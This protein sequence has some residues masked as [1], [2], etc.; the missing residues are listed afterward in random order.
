MQW[1]RGFAA[2][3]SI[4][5]SLIL[6]MLLRHGLESVAVAQHLVWFPLPEEGC[7]K[8]Q[9]DCSQLV[10]S[11][12]WFYALLP[13]AIV[14][15]LSAGILLIWA[16]R[17][18]RSFLAVYGLSAMAALF[19]ST[20][21][22]RLPFHTHSTVWLVWAPL[23]AAL[24]LL[25]A[26]LLWLTD[27]AGSSVAPKGHAGLRRV[28]WAL[29][30]NRLTIAL[31][32]IYVAMF[33]FV[34][35]TSGQAIDA[36]RQWSFS[37]AGGALAF[38][39]LASAFLLSVTIL[40]TSCRLEVRRRV[41]RGAFSLRV[42]VGVGI[43]CLLGGAITWWAGGFGLGVVILGGICLVMALFDVLPTPQLDNPEEL[44][45]PT[46]ASTNAPTRTATQSADLTLSPIAQWLVATPLAVLGMALGLVALDGFAM[47]V[48]NARSWLVL[49][50]L[51]VGLAAAFSMSAEA[52]DS[53]E[54]SAFISHRS[55][56][57][58]APAILASAAA[59][60]VT[61]SPI[62]LAVVVT[63][64]AA[65]VLVNRRWA[66]LA[67]GV[68]LSIGAGLAA[69]V[70]VHRNPIDA[71]ESI[72]TI[73]LI[74]VALAVQVSLGFAV[75]FATLRNRPPRALEWLGM[76]VQPLLT[77]LLVWWVV[78]GSVLPTGMHQVEVLQPEPVVGAPGWSRATPGLEQAFNAWVAAQPEFQAESIGIP[79]SGVR[80]DKPV[81]LMLV[82]AHGGGIRAAYWTS[83][84]MDCV[85][86]R[87]GE[88]GAW[89]DS[90]FCS[91][92]A[93]APDEIQAAA[94]RV[95]LASGVSGGSVGL[96]AYSQSL[97]SGQLLDDRTWMRQLLGNDF[98]SP[99]VGWGL[100][101][102]LPNHFLGLAPGEE[103]CV[104]RARL[105]CWKRDRAA[106]LASQLDAASDNQA[107]NL[108]Q[109]WDER[110][111]EDEAVRTRAETVPL[112]VF[113]STLVGGSG[114]AIVSAAKLGHHNLNLDKSTNARSTGSREPM[115]LTGY[116]ETIDVLCETGDLKIST[117]AVLSARFP[118]VSP[119]ARLSATCRDDGT[120]DYFEYGNCIEE[121][122]S[123]NLV[124][125]GYF[126]NSGLLT[127]SGIWPELR[128][129]VAQHN[130]GDGPKIAP[131]ILDIDS[132]YQRI[133]TGET[134]ADN[135]SE[136]LAPLQTL[137]GSGAVEEFA[138]GRIYASF[139][140]LCVVTVAPVVHPGQ[141]APLGWSMST[142]TMDEIDLALDHPDRDGGGKASGRRM[143]VPV[144]QSWLAGEEP[145]VQT[146]GKLSRCAP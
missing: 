70:A 55:L 125:G 88:T 121:P 109:T 118:V 90:R 38:V 81:P 127:V 105:A 30:R 71:G 114:A 5:G 63:A 113:N 83:I 44:E 16:E 52:T 50:T 22:W 141:M 47:G 91:G 146:K 13:L 92:E 33:L 140:R 56:R 9:P 19:S 14:L 135:A 106:V 123:M 85:V 2:R 45:G 120:K 35:Q 58:L 139:P 39:G 43:A 31:V 21:V 100:F 136:A 48:E 27:T 89:E 144:I 119:S 42:W 65:V 73:G 64:Y 53:T 41:E 111:A 78:A 51:C 87:S 8:E 3:V 80:A 98:A 66:D 93:R 102:D 79:G 60:L 82:A 25:A 99:T 17:R 23:L 11:I 132:Q 29:R 77:P 138:R 116:R 68:P 124:D 34:P 142:S 1:A 137:M 12:H 6:L 74:N 10:Q 69:L 37:R 72:G 130:K 84:V 134:E 133:D 96:A 59:G 26:R 104:D 112:L 28:A 20:I 129:L 40:E 54:G 86:A 115:P 128:R 67:L 75:V 103:P 76:R 117:A 107:P 122:C 110:F 101:H 46:V 126:D 49:C 61:T 18:S 143:N 7:P 94:R 57:L 145:T 62:P 4:I 32:V 24:L 36:V 97:L 95:F 15:L 108:R 131:F